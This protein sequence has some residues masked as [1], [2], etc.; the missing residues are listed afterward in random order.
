M[1]FFCKDTMTSQERMSAI[2]NRKPVDRVPFYSFAFG[3]CTINA[4]HTIADAYTDMPLFSE[5]NAG[6]IE[7]YV[8]DDY[9]NAGYAAFGPWEFGG[10]IKWPSGDFSQSPMPGKLPVITEEDAFDLKMPDVPNAGY[11]PLFVDFA[12]REQKAGRWYSYAVGH[13][14][15]AAANLCGPGQFAK[16]VIKKPEVAEHMLQ[17]MT[18][19]L[20]EVC[21]DIK[22]KL[23]TERFIPWFGDPTAA[24]QVISPAQFAKYAFALY[25]ASPRGSTGHGLQAYPVPYLR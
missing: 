5:D 3:F 18:D 1:S 6:A 7:Q 11:Q 20:V 15:T 22:G 21:R 10:E 8:W 23:G 9:T 4:G 16:W 25:Q 14:F 12:E 24:N 19:Y 13:P 17:I 2:L